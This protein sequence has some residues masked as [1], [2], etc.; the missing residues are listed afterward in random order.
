MITNDCLEDITCAYRTCRSIKVIG[1]TK[2]IG[3]SFC[4]WQT[5]RSEIQ[6][7]IS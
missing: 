4:F 6:A 5:L 2:I 7:K 1:N 3:T